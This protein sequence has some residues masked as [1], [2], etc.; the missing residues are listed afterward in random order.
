MGPFNQ[1]GEV[2]MRTRKRR[3]RAAAFAAILAGSGVA[4]A[5]DAPAA[6]AL[7]RA[8]GDPDYGWYCMYQDQLYGGG[9]F[10][11]SLC[12]RYNLPG[13]WRD[14]ITSWKDNQ[15][16]GA[17]ADTYTYYGGGSQQLQ[18]LFST[19]N[20]GHVSNVGTAYNDQVDVIMNC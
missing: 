19:W 16:G 7:T 20:G 18:P 8:C 4:I 9:S 5:V 14:Q 11:R 2:S 15:Y 3:I 13:E 12:G 6:S 10:G 1:I 17:T